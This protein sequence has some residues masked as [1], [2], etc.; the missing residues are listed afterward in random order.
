MKDNELTMK[1]SSFWEDSFR[2]IYP[3][4]L[5]GRGFSVTKQLLA[6]QI[7]TCI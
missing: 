7:M 4:C 1:M 5:D 3:D 2:N 6:E